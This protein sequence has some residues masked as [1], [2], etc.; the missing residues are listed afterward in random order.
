MKII[1]AGVGRLGSQIAYAL[2]GPGSEVTVIDTVRDHLNA[3]KEPVHARRIAGD[4]CDLA[5]LE[6]AGGRAAELLIAA[7]GDDEDNLVISLLAKRQLGVARVVAR[8]N[9]PDNAWL[10]DSRWG[11]DVA[12]PAE[13]ALISL[14]QEAAGA[15]D[16]VALMRLASA[17]VNIIETTIEARS[18]GAGRTLSELQLPPGCVVVAVIRHGRP[19]VPGPTWRLEPGDEL[20]VVAQAVTSDAIRTV[21]Q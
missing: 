20:L 3:M 5:V 17:G 19:S 11:V 16:T 4:A 10:F 9:D 15:S 7:T 13:T 18:R 6:R 8:V 14:I 2:G 12:L 21:F 1:I